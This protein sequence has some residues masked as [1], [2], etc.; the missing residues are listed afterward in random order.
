M[1]RAATFSRATLVR[2]QGSCSLSCQGAMA[3]TRFR[4]TFEALHKRATPQRLAL[5]TSHVAAKPLTTRSG[6]EDTGEGKFGHLHWPKGA[7]RW[8]RSGVQRRSSCGKS[9]DETVATSNFKIFKFLRL[10]VRNHLKI[11]IRNTRWLIA[12]F[13]LFV[14]MCLNIL[15]S[16]PTSPVYLSTGSNLLTFRLK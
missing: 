6:R 16:T 2:V 11:R 12:V 8:Q 9:F 3:L 10:I 7:Y 15:V 13:V 5:G 4:T 14:K 1:L